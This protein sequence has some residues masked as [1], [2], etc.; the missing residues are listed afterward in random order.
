M[1]LNCE[2]SGCLSDIH[3]RS[4]STFQV[5]N[6]TRRYPL[7]KVDTAAVDAVAH[8]GGVL[9]THTADTTGPSGALSEVLAPW[10]KPLAV[11][12]PTK[13]VTDSAL[14]L[15]LGG[16]A[17]CDAAL[18]RAEPGLHGPV[19]SQATIS[20]AITTLAQDADKALKA[21]A[22][23]RAAARPVARDLARERSP[24]HGAC[25]GE[26]IVVDLDAAWVTVCSEKEHAEHTFKRGFGFHP[27]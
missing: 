15:V 7:V 27:L 10:R 9:L 3:D 22:T 26:S 16:D 8:T 14:S 18:L 21:I 24:D 6:S 19:G 12:D 20:R 2:N 1:P 11:H 5:K 23:A 13:M 4:W 17:L 25:A